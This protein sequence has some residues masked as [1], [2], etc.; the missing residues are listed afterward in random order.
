VTLKTT[1][2]VFAFCILASGSTIKPVAAAT[3]SASISVS[4]TV[5]ASCVANVT[6]TALV[7]YAA[8]T[9]AASA[10]SVA[11]SNSAAYNVSLNSGEASGAAVAIRPLTP[12]GFAL[13]GD[14]LSS[15]PRGI[16]N[17]RQAISTDA[18]TGLGIVSNSLLAI[19]NQIPAAQCV[20][21]DAY[22]DTMIVVVTY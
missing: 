10:V 5:Q 13:L 15:T 12:S 1:L 11:C 8:A 7:V 19:H 20:L 6:T 4:A 22:I 3:A 2:P 17:R 14:A 16:P 21:P 9:D 18:A